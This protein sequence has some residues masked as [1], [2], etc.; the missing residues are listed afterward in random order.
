MRTT[1]L[2]R[3]VELFLPVSMDG[4][5]GSGLS[6]FSIGL[7]TGPNEG[8]EVCW[9]GLRRKGL[10]PDITIL[11]TSGRHEGKYEE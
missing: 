3:A 5:R 10:V 2:P 11:Y 8:N 7:W 9:A 1:L 4:M 6:S